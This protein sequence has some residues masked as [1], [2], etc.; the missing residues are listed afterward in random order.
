MAGLFTTGVPTGEARR[1][2]RLLVRTVCGLIGGMTKP[3]VAAC[4]GL[5]GVV[6]AS[7][8]SSPPY[9]PQRA[10]MVGAEVP[11]EV[12]YWRG[13]FVGAGALNLYEQGWR[14]LK[15]PR[16][17]VILIHGLKDHSSRYRDLGI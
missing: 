12:E 17:V 6:A 3:F 13:T 11:P 15:V 16:A 5:V 8:C 14:P 1:S 4:V 10:A 7:G 2:R 9:R